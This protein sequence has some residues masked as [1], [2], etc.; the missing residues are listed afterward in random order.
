MFCNLT[1]NI[2]LVVFTVLQEEILKHH[3]QV[4]QKLESLFDS[5]LAKLAGKIDKM[6]KAVQEGAT[7]ASM[8]DRITKLEEEKEDLQAK[9]RYCLVFLLCLHF[10]ST[11]AIHK[12]LF[13]V[14]LFAYI[15]LHMACINNLSIAAHFLFCIYIFVHCIWDL[16]IVRSHRNQPRHIQVFCKRFRHRYI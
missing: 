9:H 5:E 14:L 6:K 11:I 16:C 2:F 13:I 4:L 3:T 10:L 1:L 7:V 12:Q 15:Q 8:R